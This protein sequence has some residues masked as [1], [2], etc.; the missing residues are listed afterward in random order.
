MSHPHTEHDPQVR[1][2]AAIWGIA[3]GMLAVCIPLVAV[4]NS[5]IILPILTILAAGVS[6]TAIWL[7]PKRIHGNSHPQL[8]QTIAR[9]EERVNNLEIIC[10]SVDWDLQPSALPDHRSQDS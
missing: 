3:V 2:T 7:S 6:T 8:T 5:G 1:A 10:S 9:L 4:T